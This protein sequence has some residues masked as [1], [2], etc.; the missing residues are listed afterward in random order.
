MFSLEEIEAWRKIEIIHGIVS[1][2]LS[3]AVGIRGGKDQR[4]EEKQFLR[5][6]VSLSFQT[7]DLATIDI[8]RDRERGIPRYN[9]FRRLTNLPPVES[10]EKLTPNIKHSSL[11][12]ELYDNDIEKLDLLIG[13]LAEEPR[14]DGYGFGET[15]FNIF[16]LMASRRLQTDR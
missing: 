2:V 9:E 7:I 14:P 1:T 10:F 12:K 3:G 15:A 4:N 5:K 11:L 6:K 8:L 13:C 16:V